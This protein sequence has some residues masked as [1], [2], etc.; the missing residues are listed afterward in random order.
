MAW[1]GMS[2]FLKIQI[3]SFNVMKLPKCNES[4]A[5]FYM[6]LPSVQGA[7]LGSKIWAHALERIREKKQVIGLRAGAF[8]DHS[9]TLHFPRAEDETKDRRDALFL[10]YPEAV[11]EGRA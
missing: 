5:G 11:P 6:T 4:Y 2:M 9:L 1:I 8:S 3:P 10:K 7:G